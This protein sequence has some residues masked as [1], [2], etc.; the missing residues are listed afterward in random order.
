MKKISNIVWFLI[1]FAAPIVFVI[2]VF[3]TFIMVDR[4]IHITCSSSDRVCSSYTLKI[5]SMFYHGMKA[6]KLGQTNPVASKKHAEK[7]QKYFNVPSKTFLVSDIQ[8]YTCRKINFDAISKYKSYII[9]KNKQKVIL[10]QH[11]E[12]SE[13]KTACQKVEQDIK[14]WDYSKNITL[15]TE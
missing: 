8:G 13:C 1:I 15:V 6:A 3:V 10:G 5:G 9:L 4:P 14:D 2:T 11:Q 12:L 7:I